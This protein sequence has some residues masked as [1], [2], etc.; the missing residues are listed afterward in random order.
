MSQTAW[1]SLCGGKF[2]ARLTI[3]N[4]VESLRLSLKLH[5]CRSNFTYLFLHLLSY[6]Q[7]TVWNWQVGKLRATSMYNIMCT[8]TPSPCER[9]INVQNDFEW[10]QHIGS[11]TFYQAYMMTE[12]PNNVFFY[13]V[14]FPLFYWLMP[15]QCDMGWYE[16]IITKYLPIKS[17]K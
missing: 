5:Q 16:G 14:L 2:G 11:A 12:Y 15:L 1:S 4:V 6:P 8:S 9:S 17:T 10:L 7:H 13:F 3:Q